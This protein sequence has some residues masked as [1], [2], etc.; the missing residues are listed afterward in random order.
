LRISVVI[1]TIGRPKVLDDT[2]L[3]LINQTHPVDEILIGTPSTENVTQSTLQYPKV[4][5]LVTSIGLTVQRN[6]CL[7][8]VQ[9]SSDLIAF[10]DDDMEFASSYMASMAALFEANPE[11]VASS[12]NLLYDG[13]IGK[14]IGRYHARQMCKVKENLW[15][16]A[17]GCRTSP[18]N[19][20]YGCNMVYRASAIGGIAFDERLP[21]YGWLEDSDFSHLCTRGR[22]AP[23]TNCDAY[24]VHLGWR[25]GRIA[26][27][28]LGFSQIVNPFYLWKKSRVFSFSH[29]VIQCWLRCLAGNLLGLLFGESIE[30]R[31]G[32]LHGNVLGLLHLLS[33]RVD[34]QLASTLT[35]SSGCG[36][37]LPASVE[38]SVPRGRRA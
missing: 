28:R 37:G 17:D 29:I 8:Q 5:L 3:S 1:C 9:P 14:C 23:V 27:R 11:L 36:R 21:L 6:T 35:A 7:S 30:D 10:V 34:P 13:G 33:G 31:P 18:R 15:R 16:S 4:R 2:V 19:F 25:G 22:H 20:A 32:R 38:F 26:G 24:A 12:G